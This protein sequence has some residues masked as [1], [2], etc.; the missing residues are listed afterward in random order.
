MCVIDCFCMFQDLASPIQHS[1]KFCIFDFN[2]DFT[3][4]LD[5]H[6]GQ[7]DAGDA[8]EGDSVVSDIIGDVSIDLANL[9]ETNA[10]AE[11]Q[12]LSQN[13]S[14]GGNVMLNTFDMSVIGGDSNM[15]QSFDDMIA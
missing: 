15:E 9:A 7:A 4:E 12:G 14:T 2:G 3:Q 13:I 11:A 1:F 6:G 10:I 5:V 8:V